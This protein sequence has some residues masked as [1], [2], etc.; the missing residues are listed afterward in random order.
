MVGCVIK[1]K[2]VGPND[3]ITYSHVVN[4]EG[5][6]YTLKVINLR[7]I[8]CENNNNNNN[9]NNNKNNFMTYTANKGTAT[10]TTKSIYICFK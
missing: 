4:G 2:G 5:D 7:S 1:M 10:T 9:N 8:K 6:L 3:V